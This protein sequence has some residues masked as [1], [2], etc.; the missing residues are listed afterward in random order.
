[1][2]KIRVIK[3]DYNQHFVDT[4]ERPQN[5]V[6]DADKRERFAEYPKLERL[7]QLKDEVIKARSHPPQHIQADLRSFDLESLMTKF[8]VIVVDPPWEEYRQ[9]VVG[10]YR[11]KNDLTPWS[12]EDIASLRVDLVSDTPSFCFI[13][14]GEMHL[15]DARVLLNRWGF[16]RC[17]DICW[18]KTN[19]HNPHASIQDESSYLQRTKEHCLMGIKGTVK[20]ST[21]T[22][23]IHANIDT[24]VILDSE[25]VEPGST[26]KP[27]E[28]YDII[29]RF[30]LGRRKLELFGTDHNIRRGWLT[31]GKSINVS[32][33]D[34]KKY[35]SWITEN[36]NL[37][38]PTL[39]DYN[40]GRYVGTSSEIEGLRPK[41][42]PR[43][44]QQSQ[45]KTSLGAEA[46]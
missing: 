12:I 28:L 43:P 17:E 24:D 39:T 20:R 41:S 22:H 32:N 23:F 29:E 35:L 38:W 27:A 7:I 25:P 16:R 15:E 2:A 6:R 44:V 36:E 5:F 42:P 45:D 14:A 8:D 13:W 46:E 1:V 9:R 30:C 26:A 11:A 31:I 40:G 19:I 18:C 33:F 10:G 3:N 21:D 37:S 34:K 4:G